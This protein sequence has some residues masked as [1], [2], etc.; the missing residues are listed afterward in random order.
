[1]CFL[2]CFIKLSLNVFAFA[3]PKKEFQRSIVPA[4]TFPASAALDADAL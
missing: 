3:R 2:D 1:M 4:L